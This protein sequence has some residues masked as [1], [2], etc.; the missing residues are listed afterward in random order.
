MSRKDTEELENELA[1]SKNFEDFFVGNE[2]N[3][4]DF[5]LAQVICL[6]KKI[7]QKPMS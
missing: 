4:Q 6:P 5:T 3:F 7:C 2:E 1:E